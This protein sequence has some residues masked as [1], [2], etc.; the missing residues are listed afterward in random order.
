MIYFN[1]LYDEF[2]KYLDGKIKWSGKKSD[3]TKV[4]FDFFRKIIQKEYIP[5][6]E[7]QEYMSIDYIW[8][9]KIPVSS[10]DHIALALEHE[11][12][13]RKIDDILD[14]EVQHLIDIK[15]ERKIGIFYPNL[16]DEKEIIDGIKKRLKNVRHL[17]TSLEQYLFI[18]GVSTSHAGVKSMLFNGFVFS[19]DQYNN[20][21]TKPLE[22]IIIRQQ[23]KNKDSKFHSDKEHESTC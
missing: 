22:V 1:S 13:E 7:K 8:R 3:L 11:A 4:V 17:S 23:S 9:Y 15:A 18:F 10:S 21:D 12:S 20:L 16:G 5:L 6:I 2:G 14:K 19:W